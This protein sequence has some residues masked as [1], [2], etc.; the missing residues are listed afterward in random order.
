MPSSIIRLANDL[1]ESTGYKG[2]YMKRTRDRASDMKR[3]YRGEHELRQGS[4]GASGREED[5]GEG[6]S[7]R[8]ISS[9]ST[10]IY[11]N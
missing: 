6:R 8:E 7:C 2:N 9:V 5:E 1:R 11:E 3:Q 4:E 10:N